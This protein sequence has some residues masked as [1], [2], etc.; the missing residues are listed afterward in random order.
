ME[1]YDLPPHHLRHVLLN[2]F[3]KMRNTEINA[4]I[5]ADNINSVY[6]VD[7][8]SHSNCR[9]WFLRFKEGDYSV[10]DQPRLGRPSKTDEEELEAIRQR[11]PSQTQA[12]MAEPL[13]VH[14]TTVMRHLRAI[15]IR[16]RYGREVPHALTE[17]NKKNRL[18]ICSSLLSRANQK[19][20]LL[21]KIITGDESWLLHVNRRK[22]RQHLRAGEPGKVFVKPERYQKKCMLCV[23]WDMSGVVYWEL[24]SAKTTLNSTEYCRQLRSLAE[25]IREKR[26]KKTKVLLQHDNAKPH[27]SAAT[28][29]TIDE[30]KFELVPHPA[31]SPDC[32]PSDYAL[33]RSLKA[34]IAQE[35]FESREEVE[36]WLKN[37]F[38]SKSPTFFADAIL[39]LPKRWALVAEHNGDYFG[40]EEL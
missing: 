9:K 27:V 28:R 2:E 26:P 6:G 12:E 33:F 37:F 36:N 34:Q 25:A 5:A 18:S 4:R 35:I 17:D 16:Y 22:R 3:L 13:G 20:G 39:S 7:S 8:I 31:W 11:D 30:L 23:F 38:A 10:E 32:A 1:K 40:D 24:L 15:G 29:A 14:Q 21:S 19:K